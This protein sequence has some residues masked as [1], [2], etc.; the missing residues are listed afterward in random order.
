MDFL[1]A[2]LLCCSGL[3]LILAFYTFV[4]NSISARAT[5]AAVPDAHQ[6]KRF[7]LYIHLAIFFFLV[8]IAGYLALVVSRSNS[9]SAGASSLQPAA[10]TCPCPEAKPQTTENATKQIQT[11]SATSPSPNETR[12]VHS[13]TGK[14]FLIDAIRYDYSHNALRVGYRATF[15]IENGRVKFVI[16]N[17]V[18]RLAGRHEIWGQRTITGIKIGI[19]DYDELI[20]VSRGQE[21]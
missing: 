1:I 16:T 5:I 9:A 7:N 14:Y 13:A 15:F 2:I 10:A 17:P 12:A 21:G 8:T 3:S 11:N 18:F 6:R 19:A 4:I 20:K